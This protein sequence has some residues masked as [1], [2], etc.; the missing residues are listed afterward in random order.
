MEIIAIGALVLIAWV[1]YSIH[2]AKVRRQQLMQKYGDAKIVDKIMK[3]MFWQGQTS[4]QL[5]DSLGQPLDTDQRVLKTK[6]KETWKYNNTGK[7]RFGLR[8]TLENN[9]VV[10]WD[11]K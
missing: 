9:V 7:N 5:L 3:R 6:I 1:L 11:Q 2:A 4:E 8:I 10:G